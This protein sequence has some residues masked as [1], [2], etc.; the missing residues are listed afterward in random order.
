MIHV[1][2]ITQIREEHVSPFPIGGDDA[3]GLTA[4]YTYATV[5][6]HGDE[7]SLVRWGHHHRELVNKSCGMS[8]CLGDTGGKG[9]VPAQGCVGHR[10]VKSSKL[11]YSQL[12]MAVGL[13]I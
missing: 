12:F 9:L 11:L 2:L 4:C 8:A 5:C 10:E 13:N 3:D 1:R 7:R 6:D